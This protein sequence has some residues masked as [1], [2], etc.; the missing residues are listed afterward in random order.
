MGINLLLAIASRDYISD[1]EMPDGWELS[2]GY[3]ARTYQV[4]T[5]FLFS[6]YNHISSK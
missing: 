2:V 6:L 1:S 5:L 3:H 4:R